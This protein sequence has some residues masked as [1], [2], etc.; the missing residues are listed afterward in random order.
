MFSINC[1]GAELQQKLKTLQYPDEV[2]QELSHFLEILQRDGHIIRTD[3]CDINTN[4]ISAVTFNL[5]YR[6]DFSKKEV[7]I[8]DVKVKPADVFKQRFTIVDDWDDKNVIASIPQYDKPAK[9]IQAIELIHQG[10]TDSYELGY[11]LGHRGRKEKYISRHGQYAK[12]TL[13]QLKLV[14]I[15]RKGNKWPIKC[16]DKGM[17]I[18]AA[19][20]RIWQYR[21][22]IEAMLNYPPVWQVIVKVT[23]GEGELNDGLIL[24][25]ELIKNLVFPE[26][27]READT[28]NRRA[29]TL[30]NWIKWISQ[31]SGLPIRLHQDGVQ[32]S[33]PKLYSEE[34]D[35]ETD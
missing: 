35:A 34:S 12:H 33:I 16:T 24:N 15:T 7:L 19:P 1:V 4:K 3:F 8:V 28:S 31:N 27:L 17:L 11:R 30:K 22:L 25:D 13:E 21:L 26:V 18:A 9:I 2:V 10:V 29:Q 5:F 32:L 20:N 14:S 6:T 23:E